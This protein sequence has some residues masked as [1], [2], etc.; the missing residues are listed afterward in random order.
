MTTI[1]IEIT[2]DTNNVDQLKTISNAIL[3]LSN[4]VKTTPAPDNTSN[5]SNDAVE[6]ATPET[7]ITKK[8]EQV[9]TTEVKP[10]PAAETKTEWTPSLDDIRILLKAKIEK[11][12][13]EATVKLH[14]LGATGVSNLDAAKYP[15]FYNFLKSLS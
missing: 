15:D 8:T 5:H 3:A 13:E 6:Y 1:K 2:V 9:Q 11:H 12:R 10:A 4:Q 14:E 7:S